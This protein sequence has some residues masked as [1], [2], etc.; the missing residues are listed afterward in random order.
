MSAKKVNTELCYPFL[1]REFIHA[2]EDSHSA[3]ME[4][5]WHPLHQQL[6]PNTDN[7]FM[8]LYLKDHSMGEYIF[9]Y[10]WAD[11][12]HRNGFEYYPKLVSAI[13]FT[14][15]VGPRI[16]SSGSLQASHCEQLY[17]QILDVAEETAASSWHLLFP[18]K[19]HLSLFAG[20]Q[21]LERKGVQYHWFNRGYSTFDD[22]L[23]SL[24][25]RKRKMIRK[26]RR[27]IS[28]QGI[29]I[30]IHQGAQIDSHI[31]QLFYSLYERTYAKRNGTRGY[32]TRAFFLQIADSMGEQIAMAVASKN[33]QPIACALY[34]FDS[35]NLYGRYWGSID[36]FQYLHFE[37][38]YY[39]G[40]E[41]ALAKGLTKYDAGA[42]GEH[43]IIR[44][45]EPV[46]THSLHWIKQTDFRL[47]IERFLEDEK[48]MIDSYIE[49]AKEL[50][51]YKEG[52]INSKEA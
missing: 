26:E 9:D 3:C 28:N 19:H 41:F 12:Y 48:R 5:G 21:L 15:S 25:S 37:L 35:D 14:P 30:E 13:P 10:A 52:F 7:I 43:K 34:L 39:Q 33:E 20:C 24:N 1:R 32:L 40:I 49:D 47:A 2:L 17:K 51:P 6:T 36:E 8:P 22:F 50:L 46:E 31:W 29:S 4:T 45:F 38:C 11:A 44:G 18:D 42:Q 16:T 23:A 27:D